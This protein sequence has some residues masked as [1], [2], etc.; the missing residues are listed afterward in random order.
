MGYMARNR[1]VYRRQL[2]NLKDWL[3]SPRR[4]PLV[5]RGARQVGKSTLVEMLAG[6]G[7][8]GTDLFA[9][10]LERYPLLA[11]A[12]NEGTPRE[13]LNLM[14]ALPEASALSERSILFL[15][16]IQGRA[17]RVTYAQ[18]LSGGHAGVAGY[19]CRLAHGV[20]SGQP[21]VLDAGR[22]D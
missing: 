6:E 9:V 14:Q 22:Q 2:H 20:P 12:F 19:R 4:K 7:G 3:R 11:Q 13:L 18:V 17:W 10:N 15:D 5:I 16:E 8:A 1:F 21:S